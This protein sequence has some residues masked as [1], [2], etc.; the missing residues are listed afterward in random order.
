MKTVCDQFSIIL[1]HFC[2]CVIYSVLVNGAVGGRYWFRIDIFP[3]I[4]FLLHALKILGC[5]NMCLSYCTTI[6]A[7]TG[8]FSS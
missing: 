8:L 3:V 2:G 4:V 6:V 1:S 5:G 7:F